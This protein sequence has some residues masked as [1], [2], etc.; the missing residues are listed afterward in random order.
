M[1]FVVMTDIKQLVA[2][3]KQKIVGFMPAHLD[4][5]SHPSKR[6]GRIGTRDLAELARTHPGDFLSPR[7]HQELVRRHMMTSRGL[8]I[9]HGT[10]TGKT[11]TAS[12]VARDFLRT[13]RDG[14]VVVVS[15]PGVKKQFFAEIGTTV[16]AQNMGRVFPFGFE[17]LVNLARSAHGPRL[18]HVVQTYPTLMII[19]EAHYLNKQA[20]A[21][22]AAILDLAALATKVLAM[23]A[24]PITN[25]VN[26]LA[27]LLAFVT[28]DKAIAS[29]NIS[30]LSNAEL[31]ELAGCRVSV[32]H[33]DTSNTNFPV[34]VE[35]AP[36]V[37]PLTGQNYLNSVADYETFTTRVRYADQ[38]V[39]LVAHGDKLRRMYELMLQ[40]PGKTIV[41]VEM[42]QNVAALQRFLAERHVPFDTI[43]GDV[44]TT[45]RKQIVDAFSERRNDPDRLEV[46]ILSKAGQAGLDFKRVKNI[47]FLELPWN[48]SDYKQIVGRGVRFKSHPNGTPNGQRPKVN[49]FVLMYTA[50]EGAPRPVFDQ[51]AWSYVQDKKRRTDK[52]MAR[53]TPLTIEHAA[54]CGVRGNNNNNNRGRNNATAAKLGRVK[55]ARTTVRIP[56]PEP[57]GPTTPPSASTR[58]S[59]RR[60]LTTW[61]HKILPQSTPSPRANNNN[62]KKKSRPR[63]Q[64]LRR[65]ESARSATPITKRVLERVHSSPA[66]LDPAVRDRTQARAAVGSSRAIAAKRRLPAAVHGMVTRLR[67]RRETTPDVSSPR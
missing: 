18:R 46:M 47:I 45:K 12:F 51:Q 66:M 38:R 8:L 50:P 25:Q 5:L 34:M 9:V 1:I 62:N 2:T 15:P 22:G 67:R 59:V 42:K 54:R 44:G 7:P 49:V 21:R 24:T 11:L 28:G 60:S 39:K 4:V 31:R 57:N 52:I 33:R 40:H 17:E 29:R 36:V 53:L 20:S 10:G 16:P 63:S 23:T 26:E 56:S 14:L 30:A 65:T 3:Y 61:L 27:M 43:V 19:D 37:I 35:H 41:Y 55:N 64:Q 13:H 6:A 58:Q 32:Y 48:Y